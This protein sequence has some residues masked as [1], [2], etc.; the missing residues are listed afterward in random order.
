MEDIQFIIESPQNTVGHKKRPRL[1]TSCD[2]CRLKKIKCI[3]PSPE[4]K[5]EACKVAKVPCRFKDRERYFAER[6]RA[7]AGPSAN[8]HSSSYGVEQRH[9][10]NPALDAFSVASSS[11]SPS[12]SNSAPRSNSHSPKASGLVSPEGDLNGRYAYSPD[13]RRGEPHYRHSANSS[14]SSFHSR[15][16]SYG[17]S[18][19]MG[20]PAPV[21]PHP[22]ARPP[23]QTQPEYRPVQLFE[24]D[25][26]LPSHTLMQHFIQVFIENFGQEFPFLSYDQLMSDTWEGRMPPPLANA[27]AALAS[28]YATIPE[29]TIRGLHNVTEAYTEAAKNTFNAS[30]NIR[31]M[32]M[33]HAAMLLAWFE[34]KNQ[35]PTFRHYSDTAVSMA[36]ALGLQP[37]GNNM[38]PDA[39]RRRAELTWTN[40][41]QLHALTR[42]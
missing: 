34:L 9:E 37:G 12:L 3:Q 40:I 7:I 23:T 15:N 17:Y 28:R 5:C 4:T 22:N 32:E 24:S 26:D 13:P 21:L 6:S 18:N 1:V 11:S 8:I 31:S 20:S 35:R 19:Y 16:N 30:A 27:I 2:S 38:L 14:I 33:L 39:E 29:L 36:Q 25:R 10:Q 41:L 42:A